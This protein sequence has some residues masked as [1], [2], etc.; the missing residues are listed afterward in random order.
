MRRMNPQ[1][2]SAALGHARAHYDAMRRPN[3]GLRDHTLPSI[4]LQ[5]GRFQGIAVELDNFD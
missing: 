1:F 2:S 3:C 5:S 4:S